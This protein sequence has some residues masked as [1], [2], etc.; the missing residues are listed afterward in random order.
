MTVSEAVHM[1]AEACCYKRSVILDADDLITAPKKAWQ[2]TIY[3]IANI[4]KRWPDATDAERGFFMSE[5]GAGINVDSHPQMTDLLYKKWKFPVQFKKV[6]GRKT[7]T[8]TADKLALLDLFVKTKDERLLKLLR[9]RG[10][11]DQRVYLTTPRD[12][13]GRVRSSFN[14]VGTET[15]RINSYTSLTG[16][17]TNLTTVPKRARCVYVAG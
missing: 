14:L 12:S 17:G 10:K 3:R 2:T 8:I 1:A 7:A 11:I 15:G 16:S 6:K 5:I 9:L 13:D 4:A